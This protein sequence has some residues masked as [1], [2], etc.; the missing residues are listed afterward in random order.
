MRMPMITRAQLRKYLMVR[1]YFLIF[2]VISMGLPTS[3]GLV[4]KFGQYGSIQAPLLLVLLSFV[5][6][7]IWGILMW[8]L[9]MK[10]FMDRLEKRMKSD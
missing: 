4:W 8:E 7:Y 10:P 2:A 5:G 6:S 9:F 3:V 1:R